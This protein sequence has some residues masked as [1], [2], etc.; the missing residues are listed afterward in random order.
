[1]L[2]FLCGV[3]LLVAALP[4]PA[5]AADRW[6]FGVSPTFS[7]GNYGTDESTSIF[8]TPLT[9]RRLFDAGDVTVVF[10]FTCISGSGTVTIV[11]GLPVRTER[12]AAASA[13]R[14]GGGSGRG[15]TTAVPVPST[16]T[17]ANNDCGMGDIVVRG[18]YYLV[19]EHGSVPTVALRAHLKA[20]T[21]RVELGLGT[22]RPDEGIGVEIS[23][24][25]ADTFLIML[26]GG[27][28][29]IG[30]PAGVVYDNNW[31]YD[32][33]IGRDL[34]RGIVNLSVFF[35][36]DRAIVPGLQNARDVLAA[37]MLKGR[38]WRLQMGAQV[39]LS[40]G[41][42]ALGITLGASRRF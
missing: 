3:W 37:V 8:Q 6:Q 17:H 40:E 31:W 41:A 7:T 29:V 32:V 4:S 19:D 2:K 20:P 11:N 15:A 10:P 21:S 13:G 12:L 1:M 16:S 42:P 5:A 24:T 27:Y 9:A 25:I 22:G 23:R 36:E 14:T 33:G 39:G 28:T 26:D 34:A 18:R 35:E 30:Q 38:G